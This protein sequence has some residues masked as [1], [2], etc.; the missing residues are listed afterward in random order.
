[1][2]VRKL[3]HKNGIVYIQAVEKANKKY[4]VRCSFGSARTEKSTVS[5]EKVIEIVQSTIK[6]N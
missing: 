2:F 4:I 1:M 5:P 6:L 3:K